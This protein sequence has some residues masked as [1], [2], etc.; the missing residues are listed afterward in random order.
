MYITKGQI[1]ITII[2]IVYAISNYRVKSYGLYA[3]HNA[4]S[5]LSPHLVMS[6]PDLAPISS[7]ILISHTERNL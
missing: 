2:N 3:V 4:L 5:M 6:E 7:L 1:N